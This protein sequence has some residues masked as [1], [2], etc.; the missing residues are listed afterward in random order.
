LSESSVVLLQRIGLAQTGVNPTTN[1]GNVWLGVDGAYTTDFINESGEEIVLV[2]WGVAGSWVNAVKP[3]IMVT[4]PAGASQTVSFANGA[5]GA[6]APIYPDTTLSQWGQISQTW[7]E[8]TFNGQSTT[9]DVSREVNMNGRAMSITDG[10]CI[11]D[12]SR[13]VF[14]CIGG[15]ASCLTG[16]ELFNCEPGSQPG[17][18][19]GHL[20]GVDSG[21]CSGITGNTGKLTT[22]FY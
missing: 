5:S 4:I 22:I 11:S 18:H 14:R 2:V 16:Y 7:G 9:F 21:G 10:T 19:V 13:C 3:L 20:D 17:A 8:Y 12:F 1:K 6:W 15:V